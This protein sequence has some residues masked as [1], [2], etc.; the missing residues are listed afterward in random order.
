[1]R[2]RER[3]ARPRADGLPLVAEEPAEGGG[4]GVAPARAEAPDD[5]GAREVAPSG[6]GLELLEAG[7]EPPARRAHR[8]A[9]VE[10]FE[11]GGRGGLGR[12]FGGEGRGGAEARDGVTRNVFHEFAEVGQEWWEESGRG[13]PGSAGGDRA[14]WVRRTRLTRPFR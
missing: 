4:P 9:H 12:T 13:R 6:I 7:G 11:V 2:R 1:E 10:E 14:W 8:V 3:L 5:D